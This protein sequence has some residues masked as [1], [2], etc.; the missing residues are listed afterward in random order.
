MKTKKHNREVRDKDVENFKAD[1]GWR[2]FNSPSRHLKNRAQ[3]QIH[4]EMLIHAN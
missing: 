2:T 4:K 3:L 1:S